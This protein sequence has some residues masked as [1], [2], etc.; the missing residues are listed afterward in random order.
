M[1]KR[2][3]LVSRR[4][5]D[6]YKSVLTVPEPQPEQAPLEESGTRQ[7]RDVPELEPEP[8]PEPESKPAPSV[9]EPRAPHPSGPIVSLDEM[10]AAESPPPTPPRRRI[11][12][13]RRHSPPRRRQSSRQRNHARPSYAEDD[14]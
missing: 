13:V 2:Q 9:P 7:L 4:V 14:D 8:G 3:L 5:Q 6:E 10:I 11:V 12:L 1:Y